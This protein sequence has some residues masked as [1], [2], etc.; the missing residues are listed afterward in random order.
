MTLPDTPDSAESTH[1]SSDGGGGQQSRPYRSKKQRP[2]DVCRRRKHACSL[3]GKPPCRICRSLGTAC[4]FNNPPH[5]RP[6]RLFHQPTPISSSSPTAPSLP[7]SGQPE[8]NAL[9]EQTS[10]EDPRNRPFSAVFGATNASS[11]ALR[12]LADEED[13]SAH[14]NSDNLSGTAPLAGGIAN[15]DDEQGLLQLNH[16]LPLMYHQ[17]FWI[18]ESWLAEQNFGPLSLSLGAMNYGSDP[19]NPASESRTS[20]AP[21]VAAFPASDV[22]CETAQCADF[23]GGGRVNVNPAAES[24]PV[25]T[26]GGFEGD[27][28]IQ[29][30]GL[31][32]E[33]DPYV[34]QHICFSGEGTYQFG[35]YQCRQLAAGTSGGCRAQSAD[36]LPVQ[37]VISATAGIVDSTS[38]E[39]S[40]T[41]SRNKIEELMAPDIGARLVGLF[42]RYVSPSLPVLSRSCLEIKS[43]TL[44][45]EVAFLDRLPPYLLAAIYAS[46]ESFL[47]YDP[48][49]CISHLNKPF[50]GKELWDMAYQG[51]I[52]RLHTPNISVL[53]TM[54][55]YLQKPT[56]ESDAHPVENSVNWFLVSSVTQLAYRLGLQ[57]DCRAWAIPPWEKR[58]RRR[59]WWVVYAETTWRS[60]LLG[61]PKTVHADQ[62]DVSPLTATDFVMD[63]LRCPTE[64]TASCVPAL[65]DPCPFCHSGYDFGFFAGLATIASD[66]IDSFYT[67]GASKRLAHNFR[68]SLATANALLERIETWKRSLPGQMLPETKFDPERHDYF[69][70]RSSAHL[71]LTSLTLQVLIYRALLRPLAEEARPQSHTHPHPRCETDDL[72]TPADCD[73]LQRRV[74]AGN[75]NIGLSGATKTTHDAVD[76]IRHIIAFTQRL[77]SYDRNSFSYS[78][79]STIA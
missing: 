51:I 4:T 75:T 27:R 79:K 54:L 8:R 52:Q 42:L 32:G 65:Q 49:L 68:A 11:I 17:D 72:A 25:R 63:H 33:M 59:L 56:V 3:E 45:P 76:L 44:I 5:Q 73:P 48:V 41:E 58:L 66:V 78:C 14:A 53:Q 1:R 71:K 24:P 62:W 67:L 2:C 36:Q 19:L 10:E 7:P 26:L 64:E 47:R 12:S 20:N 46:A 13:V 61:F 6:R 50:Q 39:A 74:E 70:S 15:D 77:G 28:S 40:N 30:V 23:R 34:L 60:L 69:H 31:S 21:Q 35:Q 16:S 43:E 37:F 29:Y 55:I 57:F 9:A 22:Q 18:S 38:L